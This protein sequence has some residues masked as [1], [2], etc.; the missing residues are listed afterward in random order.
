[1]RVVARS[2]AEVADRL[3][4]GSLHDASGK[5]FTERPRIRLAGQRLTVPRDHF[6]DP[7]P[8]LG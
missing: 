8:A 3:D 7:Q 2:Q 5:E 4:A 6:D 1:M